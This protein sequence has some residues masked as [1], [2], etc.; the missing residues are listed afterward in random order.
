MS[1]LEK[2]NN[3]LQPIVLMLAL[4]KWWEPPLFWYALPPVSIFAKPHCITHIF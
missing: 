2:V 1:F 4:R 3:I